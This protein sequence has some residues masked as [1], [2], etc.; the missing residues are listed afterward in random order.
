M[1]ILVTAAPAAVNTT[2]KTG[3]T[4]NFLAP[5]RRARMDTEASNTEESPQEEATPGKTGSPP[6]IVITATVNLLQLQKL[7]KSVVKENSEFGNTRNGTRV[8]TKTLGDF[9]AVKSYLERN[10]LHYFTFYPKSLK[11][12]NAV[13]RHLLL[14]TPAHDYSDGLMDLGFDIISVKQMSTT[15]RSP[16]EETLYKNLP[17]FLIALPRTAKSQEIFADDT[18]LYATDRKEGFVVRKLQRG[19]SSM[20]T[21][22]ER[23]NIKIN[24]EKTQGIYFSRSRRP[25]ESHLTLNRRDI[26]FVNSAIYLGVIFDRKVTWRLHIEMIEAKAFRTFIRAYSLFKSERLSTNIKLTLHKALI[27]SVM[28][29]ASPA[30]EFAADTHL[31]KLQLLQ[32]KILRTLTIFQGAHLFAKCTLLSTCHTCITI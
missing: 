32:N 8:I 17:L 20:E 1:M 28:T 7:I 23:W 18:C 26:P 22:C 25:P 24:E 5:L 10:N 31:I 13:I 2:P 6:P 29:Y 9:A 27:R 30:W 19:L 14:N 21:R 12:I 15:R 4:R 16:S 11:P 3:P